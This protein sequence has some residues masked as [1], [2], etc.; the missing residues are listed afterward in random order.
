MFFLTEDALLICDHVVG[1]VNIVSTQNLVTIRHRHV[2]V[3]ADPEQRPI[4]MCPNI[5]VTIKPCQLTLAV[6]EGY[7][8]FI[9]I[10]GRRVCLDTVIGTTDGTPP[11]TVNYLVRDPG[12]ILVSQ[13]A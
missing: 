4:S 8:A 13:E 12:Q 2:L 3:E 7:S 11:S 9:R 6:R 10:E 1:R 5:G